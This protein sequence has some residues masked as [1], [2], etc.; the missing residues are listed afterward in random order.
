MLGGEFES[1]K[2]IHSI[3]PDFIPQPFGFGK[4]KAQRTPAATYFYLSAFI[5]MDVTTAPDPEEF[6]GRLAELHTTSRSPTGQFGF[7]VVTYDGNIPHTVKWEST[8]A[9]FF[10]NLLRGACAIDAANNEPWPELER[11][12][13]Q[14]IEVVVPRL[15]GSLRHKGGLDPI[16][17]CLIHGDLWEGNRGIAKATN[18]SVVYDASSY[19]AHNEM[20]FGNWR[21][22][23][24]ETHS[25]FPSEFGASDMLI[26]DTGTRFF[27]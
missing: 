19:F 27:A 4:F 8:W 20:E 13:R 10:S 24:Y 7:S 26:L 11:A 3:M 21:S 23:L 1:S 14:L 16:K 18:S 2:M 25:S 17:P 6:M 12:T 22:Q 9:A 5:D 15:L